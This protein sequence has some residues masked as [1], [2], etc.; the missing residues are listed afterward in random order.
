M[1]LELDE[2]IQSGDLSTHTYRVTK[3]KTVKDLLE[4][5]N[6]Q[7]KFFAIIVDGKR[8]TRGHAQRGI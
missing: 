8:R 1:E 7:N 5:L 4:E 2:I 3:E 6:L